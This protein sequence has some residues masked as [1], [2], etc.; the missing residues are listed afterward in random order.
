MPASNSNPPPPNYLDA[1]ESALVV[2]FGRVV[3][4]ALHDRVLA[5]DAALAAKKIDGITET[6]PTYRSLMV[7]Y[8]P[9]VVGRDELVAQ[10]RAL[11]SRASPVRTSPVRRTVPVCF[12]LPY[13][14][15]LAEAAQKLQLDERSVVE[16]FSKATYRL[17]MYGFLPGYAYLGKLPKRLQIPRR[18]KPR[19]PIPPGAVIIAGEQVV[20]AGVASP[21]GWH[22]IGR[23]PL[24]V[25]DL[26]RHP[27]FI[28]DVGDEIAFEPIDA[29]AFER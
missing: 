2:E 22:M 23:T 13:A 14:E 12:D 8:D 21:T 28:F 25:L 1:G 15:D 7:H 6:V 27:P 29:A 3:D 4:V 17:Y 5:L 24:R 26:N 20:I 11:L 18:E 16:I 19:S 10:V 9:R